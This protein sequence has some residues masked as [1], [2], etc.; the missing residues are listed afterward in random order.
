MLGSDNSAK[1]LVGPIMFPRPGP[2]FAI[3]VAAP[4][5][6]VKKSLPRKDKIKVKIITYRY[7]LSI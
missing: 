4:D 6:D 7:K 3:L 1:V 5:K 2:T